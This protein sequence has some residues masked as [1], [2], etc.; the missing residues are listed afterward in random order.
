MCKN[1]WSV[2]GLGKGTRDMREH[3]EG[4]ACRVC[5]TARGLGQRAQRGESVHRGVKCTRVQSWESTEG[6]K[7][8]A[9]LWKSMQRRTGR[10]R[11]V[12]VCVQVCHAVGERAQVCRACEGV[13]TGVQEHVQLCKSMRRCVRL[14][15]HSRHVKVC[16]GMCKSMHRCVQRCA[17]LCE[18][19]QVWVTVQKHTQGRKA[20]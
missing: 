2:Q 8:C 14:W 15:Q 11:G 10:C 1:V 3:K 12:Q 20:V 18:C 17:R 13:C 16:A 19:A 7:E 5:A 9:G 6:M 4:A